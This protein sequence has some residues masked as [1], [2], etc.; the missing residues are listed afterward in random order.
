[1]KYFGDALLHDIT[2]DQVQGFVSKKLA[3]GNLTPTTINNSVVPLKTIF[4]HAVLGLFA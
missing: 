4:K 1:M 3:E 2:P